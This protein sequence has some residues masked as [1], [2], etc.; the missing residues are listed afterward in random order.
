MKKV[1]KILWE[2]MI[3]HEKNFMIPLLNIMVYYLMQHIK[4][5]V[6]SHLLKVE[7]YIYPLALGL[8]KIQD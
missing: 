7:D 8:I 1:K 5:M 2:K 4:K 6:A 3:G